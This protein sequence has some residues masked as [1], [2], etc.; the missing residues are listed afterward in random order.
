MLADYRQLTSPFRAKKKK[1]QQTRANAL[2]TNTPSKTSAVPLNVIST[3]DN[4][5][6][7]AVKRDNGSKNYLALWEFAACPQFSAT[8]LTL[9]TT[10][11]LTVNIRWGGFAVDVIIIGACT[12]AEMCL[13]DIFRILAN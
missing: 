4:G 12:T 5:D 1:A 7:A 11:P 10:L 6:T 9:A 3:D 2:L 13:L 8:C